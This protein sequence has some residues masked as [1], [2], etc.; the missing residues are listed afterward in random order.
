MA[1]LSHRQGWSGALY[2]SLFSFVFIVSGN[3]TAQ[4][5]TYH[6]TASEV[7]IAFFATDENNHLIENVSQDDFAVVDSGNVIRD[8]RSLARTE[9]TTFRVMVLVDASESVASQ[10]RTA[11]KDVVQLASQEP[12]ASGDDF[13]VASFSG[14]RPA[15]LCAGDCRAPDLEMKL[16]APKNTGAT[17]LFDTLAY[18]ADFVSNHHTAA[19]R[20]VVI[21][22]SDGD[23]TIS[24]TSARDAVDAVLA[25]GALLYTIN[26]NPSAENSHGTATLEQL[27][28]A[29]GGRSFALNDGAVNVVNTVL[30]DLRASYVVTY[31]LPER[32]RGFHSLRIL[33]KYNLKLRFH[34]RRG[35][36]YDENR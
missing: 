6:A 36:F 31:R 17:P 11:V 34:C 18:A 3:L 25:T 28:E 35:Y 23:D 7:R 24:R 22:F 29:S 14:L 32:T 33:P 16:L 19:M 12:L 20:D 10:L 26:M 13:S 4:S 1:M 30:A 21:L 15:L 5:V 27:A 9:E 8:F 2:L